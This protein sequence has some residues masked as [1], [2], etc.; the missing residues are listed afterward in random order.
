MPNVLKRTEKHEYHFCTNF[1]YDFMHFQF[2]LDVFEKNTL[3][4]KKFLNIANRTIIAP[5]LNM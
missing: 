4:E 2:E 5:N 1:N 3:N